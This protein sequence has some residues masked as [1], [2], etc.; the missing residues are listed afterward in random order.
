[1]ASNCDGVYPHATHYDGRNI[2]CS[3]IAGHN[4]EHQDKTTDNV[5]CFD[6]TVEQV[7]AIAWMM[8]VRKYGLDTANEMFRDQS[9]DVFIADEM[10]TETIIVFDETDSIIDVYERKVTD[11]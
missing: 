3:L 9:N 11:N 4:G 2:M 5:L 1:M 8:A 7:K 10:A 6:I